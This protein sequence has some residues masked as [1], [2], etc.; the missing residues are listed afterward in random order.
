MHEQW[1][2]ER[3]GL[4]EVSGIRKVFELGASLI[5]PVNL[6]IG[7]PDFPVPAQA[8]EAAKRAIDQDRNGYTVTQGILPLRE[9]LLARIKKQYP[10]HGDRSVLVTSGTSGGLVLSLFCTLNP[11]DEVIVFDPYFVMYPHFIR[12]AGGVPVFLDTYP[13]FQID[14][15]RVKKALSARTKVIIV[16]S[17]GNPT[18][19]VYAPEIL[20]DLAQ[21]AAKNNL[22]LLSDEVYS[23]FSYDAA[24][25]SPA[26]F[27]PDVL[28]LDGFSKAYGM[29]GWRLGYC[30]GPKRLIEEMTKLQQFTFVCAP[31]IAQHG[32]VAA[33]DAD[34]SGIVSDYRGK[35]DLM[36]E[37]LKDAYELTIPGG[38]FYLFPKAPWG[39]G[40]EF[41]TE[42]I[43]NN[44]LIIPGET[45]SR[46][47]THF[48][49]S[50]AANEQTLKRGIEI[51]R[52]IARQ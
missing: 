4:V 30:H 28:V 5:D 24:F 39:K 15:D 52:R 21:L 40:S 19:A 22:L 41:V 17:P 47:D 34:L 33:L 23:A 10:S 8:K 7:Q 29:T 49:I 13:D 37:G 14:P 6:S 35:R 18:G 9:K 32:G 27:N 31:S 12:I 2:A 3:M 25:A 16:N 20:R 26:E 46:Q 42:A 48:R 43:R 45:F 50:Y 38:A 1:I 36:V 11:G 44:L 51:L